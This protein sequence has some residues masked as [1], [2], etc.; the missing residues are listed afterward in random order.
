MNRFSATR[1]VSFVSIMGNVFLLV[2]KGIIGFVCN[3]QAMVADAFN[4]V[5]DILTSLM[6]FIGNKISSKEADDDHHM[7]HGKAEY[8]YSLLIS[9]VMI[10]LSLSL[11]F[12]SFMSFFEESSFVFSKYLIVVCVCTII[13]KFGLYLFSRR[14]YVKF[15]NILLKSISMDHRN[16]CVL[17][18][19]NLVSILL[20]MMGYSFADG[21]VSI[22]ISLWII[23]SA[24]SLFRQSYDVLMDKAMGS[25]TKDKVLDIISKHKEIIKINHFNTV[26][27]GYQ[28]QIS[29]TIFVDGNMSTFESH[30]IANCLEKEI[31]ELV[32][33]VYLTVIH[34]NPI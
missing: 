2:I 34:V 22:G 11:I 16:D 13:L 24:I 7:G 27:V 8:I 25:D 31:D 1:L 9:V 29:F 12:S 4:S 19:F 33:E 14:L 20:G 10:Y 3:S 23:C 30:E 21:V 6:T 26:P 5:G 32:D 28:Y 17:T 18:F 15:D